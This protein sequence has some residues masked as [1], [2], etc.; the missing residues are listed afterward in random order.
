MATW[1]GSGY[2]AV[3]LG[4]L[5]GDYG[6]AVG[7]NDLGQATG[8]SLYPGDIHGPAF[9]SDVHGL[10]A[11]PQLPGDTDGYGSQINELGQIVGYSQLFDDNGN[12]ISQRVAIWQGGTVTEL[13]TLIPS[14]I[15]TLIDVGYVNNFG[16]ISADSGFLADGTEAAYLLVPI[17]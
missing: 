3:S 9:V 5:G 17:H 16:V 12:F 15:P 1:N 6:E 2:S 4:S 14:E 7:I 10:H 11:L 13:Q 8:W